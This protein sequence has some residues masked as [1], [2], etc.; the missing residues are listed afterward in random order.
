[1][2]LELA[3][4]LATF[5][6]HVGGTQFLPKNVPWYMK[7]SWE[8]SYCVLVFFFFFLMGSQN[9]G[10]DG[11]PEVTSFYFWE[12]R[13]RKVLKSEKQIGSSQEVLL[14]ICSN[15]SLLGKVVP[16]SSITIS[17]HCDSLQANYPCHWYHPSLFKKV[18]YC[19]FS[20]KFYLV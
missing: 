18:I 12:M 19:S 17:K 16:D 2:T 9:M 10:A 20:F 1:M 6:S 14:D 13:R 5:E 4:L 15:I 8:H 11:H 3:D 7:R